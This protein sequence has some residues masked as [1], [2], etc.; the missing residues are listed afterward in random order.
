MAAPE[1]PVSKVLDAVMELPPKYR[2]TIYLYYYEGYSVREIAELLGRSEA[3]VSAHLSRGR[4]KLRI[5]LG[6]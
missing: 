1:I 6:G 4:N 2:E 3:A 5:T